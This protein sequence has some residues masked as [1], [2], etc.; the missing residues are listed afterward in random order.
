ML[1]LKTDN[2]NFLKFQK[3]D[4]IEQRAV[5]VHCSFTTEEDCRFQLTQDGFIRDHGS[6][7]RSWLLPMEGLGVPR[8]SQ[9]AIKGQ[10]LRFTLFFESLPT[11]C[12]VFNLTLKTD[13][14]ESLA[15]LDVSRRHNDVYQVE[16]EVAPF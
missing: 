14:G 5:V 13:D 3:S 4:P 10:L 11:D 15:V 1:H 7:H 9:L 6:E 16:L 2:I 12:N 8:I